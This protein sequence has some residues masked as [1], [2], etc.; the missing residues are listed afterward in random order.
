M[1]LRSLSP[2]LIRRVRPGLLV[3]VAAVATLAAV[4]PAAAW[5][6]AVDSAPDPGITAR[7][8][9]VRLNNADSEASASRSAP[10]RL[11]VRYDNVY[12]SSGETSFVALSIGWAGQPGP[13]G[14]VYNNSTTVS[15]PGPKS[16]TVKNDGSAPFLPAF[17][18]PAKNG[19]YWLQWTATTAGCAKNAFNTTPW[20]PAA[21]PNVFT[22]G[23][24]WV[25]PRVV[26]NGAATASEIRLN[27]T[28]GSILSTAGATINVKIHLALKPACTTCRYQIVVGWA[29]DPTPSKCL[30][31]G[32][33]GS[34]GVDADRGAKLIVP[35]VTPG[36]SYPPNHLV[37]WQIRKT[38][39][40]TC[41]L[42]AWPQGAP[43]TNPSRYFLS[44]VVGS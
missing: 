4:V 38:T 19:S 32:V 8:S 40:A 44:H 17:K 7:L 13:I 27:G 29:T 20:V 30:Y 43:P 5:D 36:V 1:R 25:G 26:K 33:P 11:S 9:N 15:P 31:N 6:G 14:C 37:A 24:L 41:D 21:D 2:A 23:H 34:K 22:I 12:N 18:A 28:P 35:T 39:S 10:V 16:G 3:T 42:S